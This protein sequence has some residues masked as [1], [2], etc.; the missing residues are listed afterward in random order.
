MMGI[1]NMGIDMGDLLLDIDCVVV[2][3]DLFGFIYFLDKVMRWID[4][5]FW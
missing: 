5:K 3:V 4:Y 2:S 1:E